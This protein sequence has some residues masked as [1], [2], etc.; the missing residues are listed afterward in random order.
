MVVR[1]PKWAGKGIEMR[2]WLR[3]TGC[4]ARPGCESAELRQ[5]SVPFEVD[6]R[7]LRFGVEIETTKRTR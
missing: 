1:S 3:E 5:P 7:D 6:A 4:T 2:L